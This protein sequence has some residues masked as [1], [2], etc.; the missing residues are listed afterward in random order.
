M[1]PMFKQIKAM[2]IRQFRPIELEDLPRMKLNKQF[3]I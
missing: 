1:N 3:L 2:D